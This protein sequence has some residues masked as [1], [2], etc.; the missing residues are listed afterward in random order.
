MSDRARTR[1]RLTEA[2]ALAGL[3][4]L[5][6]VASANELAAG[7]ATSGIVIHDAAET[8]RDYCRWQGSTLVFTIPGGASW[9]LVTTTADAAIL[10]PGDGQFHAFD[11]AEVRAALAGVRYPLARV[12]AEVFVLPYPRRAQLESAAGPGLILLSP[13]V[14]AL[15]AEQQHAEFTHELGHVVQY[16]LMPDADAA[17]WGGYRQLRGITDVTTYSSTSAHGDRPH[18]IFAEDFRALFGDAQANAAGT[19]ENATLAYPTS[20][21]GLSAFVLDLAG[22]PALATP[23]RVASVVRGGVAT[24]ARGGAGAAVLDLFDVTGRRVAAIAPVADANGCRWTWDG[25]DAS[26]AEQRGAVFF[27]RARDGKGGIARLVR[28]P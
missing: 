23:L 21:P 28:L 1:A 25:R 16:T 24:F 3:L 9:E 6:A 7:A 18:E 2:L 13:G 14:R 15:P 11:A 26:G 8:L 19:I 4:A 12:S 10:N 5:P 17:A 27:A 20:V 22:A